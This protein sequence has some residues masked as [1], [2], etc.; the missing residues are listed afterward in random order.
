MPDTFP[1]EEKGL[2]GITFLQNNTIINFKDRYFEV[3]GVKYPFIQQKRVYLVEN[4]DNLV[5]ENQ[6]MKIYLQLRRAQ[7]YNK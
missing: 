2:I 7:H 4:K 1:M 3:F 6:K 5:A